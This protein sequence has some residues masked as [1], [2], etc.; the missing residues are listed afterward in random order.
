MNR[1]RALIVVL[2]LA[3]LGLLALILLWPRL[4]RPHTLSG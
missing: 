1:Q 2:V 3:G 4:H